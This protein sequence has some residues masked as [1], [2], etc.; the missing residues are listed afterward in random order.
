[1][2]QLHLS[3]GRRRHRR[4]YRHYN[5]DRCQPCNHATTEIITP[6]GLVGRIE[7]RYSHETPPKKCILPTQHQHCC[8]NVDK[9]TDEPRDSRSQEDMEITNGAGVNCKYKVPEDG[10]LV[11]DSPGVMTT[12]MPCMPQFSQPTFF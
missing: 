7:W 2:N 9:K 3:R 6:N 5:S 11:S 8:C 1:M 10:G 12:H 4:R